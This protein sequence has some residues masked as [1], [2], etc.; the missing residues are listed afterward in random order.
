VE[1]PARITQ[2]TIQSWISKNE[3]FRS[4]HTNEFHPGDTYYLVASKT[5]K[6]LNGSMTAIANGRYGN[7]RDEDGV[8]LTPGSQEYVEVA[9]AKYFLDRKF[10][11]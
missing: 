3:S 6:K 5:S 1:G 4:S 8:L 7:L 9:I 11:E 10:S 2:S